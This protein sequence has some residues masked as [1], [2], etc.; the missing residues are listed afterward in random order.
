METDVAVN[1]EAANGKGAAVE[2][3]V[4][5]ATLAGL[6]VEYGDSL[7][8]RLNGA[9]PFDL[10]RYAWRIVDAAL[11][12]RLWL[13]W[14]PQAHAR[15][16]EDGFV[17]AWGDWLAYAL[18]LG[19]RLQRMR[20][21]S[22]ALPKSSPGGGEWAGAFEQA[23]DADDCARV[24]V[25]LSRAQYDSLRADADNGWDKA[26]ADATDDVFWQLG[27]VFAP[28][29]IAL[30]DRLEPPSVRLE[31]NDLYLPAQR[32]LMEHEVLVED[33]VDR[34][35]LLNISGKPILH[36][37]TGADCT[38]V[39]RS[40]REAASEAGLGCRDWR[41]Y[42]ALL[43]SA[44]VRRA[45]AGLM[46][47]T[48]WQLYR[49]RLR[50]FHADLVAAVDRDLDADRIVQVLR[51]LLV[52]KINIRNLAVI[53]QALLEVRATV[54]VNQSKLIIFEPASG[55]VYPVQ[56]AKQAAQLSVEDLVESVRSRLRR[57]ISHHYS[58]GQNTLIVYLV[59]PGVEERLLDPR[60]L[61]VAEETA[62]LKGVRKE[63]GSL[64]PTAANP[65]VLTT[66]PVRL[67][68]HRLIA[69][70]YPHLAVV[71][72]QEL[73]PDMNIQPIARISPGDD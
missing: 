14:H 22:A 54:Q 56:R 46:N 53:L 4:V 23:A 20:A 64:P 72:Y 11:A 44:T 34:L 12:S 29:A 40:M 67:R 18:A 60:A 21:V 73:S 37:V 13:E 9:S 15:L 36:P 39:D 70:D 41:G 6:D 8:E 35:H 49:L 48:L 30:D 31:W 10:P 71:S 59:D 32:G 47:R 65:V 38:V 24:R 69:P 19:L 26:L 62:I 16:E 52:E 63:V 51:S 7:A 50:D 17:A 66:S 57:P 61:S 28:A 43:L 5:A 45:A 3:P 25:F 68:V 27:L 58:R 2:K 55:G 33:S 1:G 42:L